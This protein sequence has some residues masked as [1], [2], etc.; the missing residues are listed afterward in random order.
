MKRAHSIDNR[1]HGLHSAVTDYFNLK[2]IA[3]FKTKADTPLVVHAY[4]QGSL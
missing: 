3:A 2:G 1:H 4:A